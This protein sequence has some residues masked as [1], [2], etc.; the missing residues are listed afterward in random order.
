MTL[1]LLI[2]VFERDKLIDLGLNYQIESDANNIQ[3]YD[4]P[5]STRR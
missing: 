3:H 2:G 4:S 1:K 5:D